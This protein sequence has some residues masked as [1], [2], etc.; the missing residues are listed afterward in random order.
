VSDEE[1]VKIP[2]TWVVKRRKFDIFIMK[3]IAAILTLLL[4]NVV[5]NIIG[6]LEH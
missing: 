4:L 2:A 5:L 3:S 6:L 1:H